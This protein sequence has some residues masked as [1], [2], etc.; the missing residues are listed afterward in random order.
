MSSKTLL[1]GILVI[2]MAVGMAGYF[3]MQKHVVKGT[4]ESPTTVEVITD[5]EINSL[6]EQPTADIES[7][8]AELN[9][10]ES[11]IDFDINLE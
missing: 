7:I 8:E 3:L 11:D 10:S 1:I 9:I 2:L 4:T 6:V 5:E